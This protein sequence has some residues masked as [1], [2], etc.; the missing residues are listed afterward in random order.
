MVSRLNVITASA[1]ELNTLAGVVAGTAGNDKAVV[2]SGSGSISNINTLSTTGAI[3]AGAPLNGFL[4]YGNQSAITSVGSLT[5]LGIHSTPTDEYFAITG[6]GFD[7]L[8]GSYTR[9]LTFSGS[10]LTPV[11]FQIEV[12]NG[13]SATAANA[14][15]IGNITNN[16]LRFG[17]NN[18]TSMILT[19]TGRLGIGTTRPSAPLHV[20]GSNNFVF[21]TGGTTVYCLRTDNGATESALGPITDDIGSEIETKHPTM[22]I[23]RVKR[24]YDQCEVKLYDWIESENRPGQEVGLITQDL[25]S[26]HLT[27]LISVFY[28]DDIEKGEDP[29]LEPGKT[30]LNVDYSRISAYNMKMIQHMIERGPDVDRVLRPYQSI[31]RSEVSPL[32]SKKYRVW[33]RLDTE[34]LKKVDFGAKGYAHYRDQTPLKA[35]SHLDHNDPE[36]RKRYYLRH[37]VDYPPYSADFLSKRYLW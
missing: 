37:K 27:D 29:S 35:Y 17:V 33:I 26:A 36:R 8:D 15:W 32:S 2:L 13:T 28:R 3:T 4:A 25:V 1:T 16:D 9:M 11:Q 34:K 10:N 21:G 19:T 22:P 18:S 31:E 24:L 5:E 23:D 12:H 6:S 30:Q 20:P 7:Y 14:S